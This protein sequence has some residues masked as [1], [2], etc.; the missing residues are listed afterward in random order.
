MGHLA[1]LSLHTTGISY[2]LLFWRLMAKVQ[3]H[4]ETGEDFCPFFGAV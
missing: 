4:R 1:L 2:Y 3:P